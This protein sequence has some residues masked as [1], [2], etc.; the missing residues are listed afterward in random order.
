MHLTG[1]VFLN[2]AFSE[3]SIIDMTTLVPI[4]FGIIVVVLALLLRSV[5]ATLATMLVIVLSIITAIGLA[6][7]MGIQLDTAVGEFSDH[8][9]DAGGG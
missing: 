2:N 9:P 3:N 1:I 7:W 5:W 4:M 8:D 6:G